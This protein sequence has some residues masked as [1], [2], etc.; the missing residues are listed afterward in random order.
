[1][2]SARHSK[3]E[4]DRQ[5]QLDLAH[6][7]TQA[8]LRSESEGPAKCCA[9]GGQGI[10]GPPQLT[11]RSET[12]R[13]TAKLAALHFYQ[14]AMDDSGGAD[15]STRV[16]WFL[17]LYQGMAVHIEG[18]SGSPSGFLRSF[19]QKAWRIRSGNYGHCP[20]APISY[21]TKTYA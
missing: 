7:W 14:L 10:V 5:A 4:N 21:L 9:P 17:R 13:A 12:D 11:V 2:L 1:M 8:A 16:L 6:T 19:S 18:A 15:G 3:T 20:S